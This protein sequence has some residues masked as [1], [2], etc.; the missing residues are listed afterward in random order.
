MTTAIQMAA[1]RLGGIKRVVLGHADADHRGAAP[2]LDAPVYCHPAEREAA[3]SDDPLRPYMHFED[4][5]PPGGWVLP[6]LMPMWDGGAVQIA[7]TVS[8]GDEVAGFEVVELPGHAPGQ[9]GLFRERDRLALVSDCF[10]TLDARTGMK[11]APRVPHPS[12]NLSSE[13]AAESIRKLAGMRPS[14]AWAGHADP[15]T[16][17]VVSQLHRAAETV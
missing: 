12:T 1:S 10:Y 5:E 15:V 6:R 11:S 3:E 14:A 7:G 13:E 16:G 9:I 2:G 17:D 4:L 8:Q